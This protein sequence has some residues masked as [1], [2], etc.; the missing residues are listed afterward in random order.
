[1]MNIAK[2]FFLF[3]HYGKSVVI[4]PICSINLVS[5]KSDPEEKNGG[6]TY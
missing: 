1:M 2:F 4:S 3:P 6:N 5:P